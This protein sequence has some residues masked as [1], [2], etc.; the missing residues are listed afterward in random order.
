MK[1]I[2]LIISFLVSFVIQSH[3]QTMSEMMRTMPDTIISLLS[4][5]D[6]LDFVDYSLSGECPDISNMLGGKSKMNKLTSDYAEITLTPTSTIQFKLLELSNLS[7]IL[8]MVKTLTIDSLSD[9]EIMFFNSKWEKLHTYDYILVDNT[10]SYCHIT[11]SETLPEITLSTTTITLPVYE[12]RRNIPQ[13]TDVTLRW[14]GTRLVA[15]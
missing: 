1:R 13:K 11:L 15:F 6:R 5:N 12:E 8:C 2:L 3:S 9:S 4:K 10:Q 14:D 7:K